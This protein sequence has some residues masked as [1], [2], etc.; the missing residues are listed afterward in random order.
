MTVPSYPAAPLTV[1][2][3]A[4]CP[5]LDGFPCT[6]NTGKI[7]MRPLRR[8]PTPRAFVHWR[9][10]NADPR[11]VGRRPRWAGVRKP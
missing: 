11:C 4:S 8:V 6:D 1:P 2:F 10:S 7:P 5:V 9:F 3:F